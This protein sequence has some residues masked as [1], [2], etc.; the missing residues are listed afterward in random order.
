MQADVLTSI[1]YP[2]GG[3][4]EFMYEPHDYGKVVHRYPFYLEQMGVDKMAGGLRIRSIIDYPAEGKAETRTFI[5]KNGN[6][7]SGI[8][9]GQPQNSDGDNHYEMPSYFVNANG[10]KIKYEGTFPVSYKIY[11]ED[12]VNE[13]STTEG[14][15]VTYS[16]VQEQRGDGSIVEYEYSNHDSEEGMDTFPSF[17]D[18]NYGTKVLSDKAN[19][20]ELFRGLLIKKTGRNSNGDMC[21]T[22]EN[23]YKID[24]LSSIHS[25][26][27]KTYFG[28][29]LYS[30][31]HGTIFCGYPYLHHQIKTTYPDASG[32][33][34]LETTD[35]T[36]DIHRNLTQV[37]RMAGGVRIRDTYT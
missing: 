5:Y 25:I 7:S 31:R 3:R 35:Y 15:H 37:T 19:S 33:S 2:T 17:Y 18:K 1:C 13:L 4:S 16:K 8:L 11:S 27:W 6:R 32:S 30:L 26:E 21:F 24:T 12:A 29:R 10:T 34:Y 28:Q 23:E 36:Y 22:E 14:N 20:R 9:S